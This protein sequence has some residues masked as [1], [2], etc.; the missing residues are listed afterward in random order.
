LLD[1]IFDKLDANRVEQI[2]KLVLD[3]KFGQIFVTDTN[4]EYIDGLLEAGNS[5]YHLYQVE[6]GQVT[7]LKERS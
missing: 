4:R 5:P 2:L 3:A 1:D 6:Q 7:Q